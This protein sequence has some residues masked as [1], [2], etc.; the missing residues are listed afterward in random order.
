MRSIEYLTMIH[1]VITIA[2]QTQLTLPL[3]KHCT[4]PFSLP[5]TVSSYLDV[6]TLQCKCKPCPLILHKVQGNLKEEI[7]RQGNTFNVT[8]FIKKVIVSKY[9]V[10]R[11]DYFL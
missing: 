5:Q 10:S 3:H 6:S 11:L 4:V 9:G 1:N 8:R 2:L 7:Y